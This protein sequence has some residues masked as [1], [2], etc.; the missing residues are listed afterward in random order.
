[1]AD[2]LRE[3]TYEDLITSELDRKLSRRQPGDATYR[4]LDPVESGDFLA[5]YV[6][7]VVRRALRAQAGSDD[8]TIER[9]VALANALLRAL[10]IQVPEVVSSPDDLV[11]PARLLLEVT[12]QG[13]RPSHAPVVRPEVPLSQSALLVNAHGQPRIG[14]EIAR[15][16]ATATSVDLICAFI[17]WNGYRLV[18]DG[19]RSLIARGGSVR[20]LTTTYLGS[21]EKRALDALVGL[22]ATVRVSYDV[23][24]TRLHAKAWLF[25][26][27]TLAT[28]YVGS[29]NLTK[30]ALVDGLEWNVRLSAREHPHLV[31]T[32]QAAFDDLWNDASFEAYEPDVDGQRL[33]EALRIER[34]GSTDEPLDLSFLDVRPFSYQQEVL[35]AVEAE[36][37][38]HGRSKNLIV[39]ATG[40]GKTVVAA[41]DYRR[42][43][44]AGK[45]DRLL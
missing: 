42:L 36:R 25:H 14:T 3:G 27:P 5:N 15:E 19:L 9:Q 12:T 8:N 13:S 41:L 35:D 6:S 44:Q 37:T 33:E 28:A 21:T 11:E 18:A 26:R 20:V 10:A 45:L 29:S 7:A 22:G 38:L 32:F 39:M 34:P 31:A 17:K 30:T 43:R 16:L 24:S 23:H 40:T 2:E 1:V 4:S